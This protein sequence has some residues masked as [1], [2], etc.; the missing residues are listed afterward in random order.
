MTADGG[1]GTVFGWMGHFEG[2]NTLI[3]AP[4][5]FVDEKMEG[6]ACFYTR[7]RGIELVSGERRLACKAAKTSYH[8][9]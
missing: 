8:T 6:A 3:T 5:T 9:A 2:R 7:R 4:F 1:T